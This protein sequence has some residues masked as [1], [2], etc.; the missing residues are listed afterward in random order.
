MG[1]QFNTL[2][3]SEAAVLLDHHPAQRLDLL[4]DVVVIR[5][6]HVRLH[7]AIRRRDAD[8][9]DAVR[10]ERARSGVMATVRGY[11]DTMDS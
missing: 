5:P 1:T 11:S 8:G 3:G 2:T 10:L 9:D 6:A 4:H 7:A